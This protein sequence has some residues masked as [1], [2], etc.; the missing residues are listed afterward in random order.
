[1]YGQNFDSLSAITREIGGVWDQLKYG[2]LTIFR[3]LKML[4]IASSHAFDSIMRHNGCISLALKCLFGTPCTLQQMSE[5]FRFNAFILL[6]CLNISL[7]T[8][9]SHVQVQIIST[10]ETQKFGHLSK[11][12]KR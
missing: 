4:E 10:V 12:T 5:F 11:C 3:H 6:M 1:M 9:S 2:F 7:P 8:R